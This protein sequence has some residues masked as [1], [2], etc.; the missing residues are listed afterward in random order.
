[1]TTT[2]TR[3]WWKR[4]DGSDDADDLVPMDTQ[5]MYH[6]VRISFPPTL[7]LLG[8][9]PRPVPEPP[10]VVVIC[11]QSRRSWSGRWSRSR[12]TPAVVGGCVPPPI[13]DPFGLGFGGVPAIGD[14]SI[15]FD[16]VLTI[17]HLSCLCSASLRGSSSGTRPSSSTPASTMPGLPG[18]W[19]VACS[20]LFDSY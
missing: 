3:R 8:F 20:C 10:F 15:Q 6:R 17:D 12:R 18:N 5:G 16:L 13:P 9:Q 1:M 19:L 11:T 7:L 4:R 2:A 14:G